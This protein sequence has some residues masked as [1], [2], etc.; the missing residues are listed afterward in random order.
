MARINQAAGLENP[1]QNVFPQPVVAQ[2]APTTNDK[3]YPV[4]QDWVDQAGDTAYKLIEVVSN[5]ATWVI[6]GPGAS[7]VDTLT[8]DSG[9]AISPAAGNIT[10][11]G[12]ASQI[13]TTGSGSTITWSLPAAITAPGSLTTTTT[14]AATTTVTGGT[15]VIATTGGVTA[16]AGGVTATAGNITAVADDIV[17][18]A[19]DIT[20]TAGAVSAGTTVTGGTGVV[21]T[22]GGVTATAGD[23]TATAGDIVAT[24]GNIEIQ[25]AGAYLAVEG[26]AVTDFIGTGTLSSGTVTIANTNIAAGDVILLSRQS[27]NGS[28]ALGLY[29]YSISAS[30]SFTVTSVQAGTPAS[31]ETNDNSIFTYV[32]V[33]PL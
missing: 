4:G 18:T 21:A 8:G 14:L 9:G 23:I 20:A 2:R 32:I 22:T 11:A 15:G 31:T 5:S 1:L 12:T 6:M 17:A 16:T 27:I 13:T 26:G 3:N 25:G 30:T 10:L 28:S 19:G 24:A 29:T 7:D 33:R